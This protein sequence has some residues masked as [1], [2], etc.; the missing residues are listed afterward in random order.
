MRAIAF[1]L[2]AAVLSVQGVDAQSDR[3]SAN[4]LVPACQG[5][6]GYRGNDTLAMAFD[7]GV[8]SGIFSGLDVAIGFLPPHARACPPK[9]VTNAQMVR[10]ALAYIERRPERRHEDFRFLA[11]E[12]MHEA[13][14][15]PSNPAPPR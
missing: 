4:F 8:C 11:I 3:T 10:V 6:L 12:A 1:G 9:I 2:L 7:Q 13:W 14:P 5:F 15:C